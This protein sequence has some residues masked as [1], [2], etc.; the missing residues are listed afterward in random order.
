MKGLKVFIISLFIAS[1]FFILGYRKEHEI[2]YSLEYNLENCVRIHN[3]LGWGSGVII[4]SNGLILTAAHVV[5]D[6]NNFLVKVADGNSVLGEIVYVDP[7]KDFAFIDIDYNDL[8]PS[9]FA[10]DNPKVG[11]DIYIIGSPLDYPLFNV[12]T[13][14]KVSKLDVNDIDY[15]CWYDTPMLIVDAASWPGNSGGPVFNENGEIIGILVGGYDPYDNLSICVPVSVI[16][17]NIP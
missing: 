14:G 9:V 15:Y 13:F 7:N 11:D 17:N 16:I 1:L 6:S 4:D 2:I 12:T 5:K 8:T 3:G 10:A